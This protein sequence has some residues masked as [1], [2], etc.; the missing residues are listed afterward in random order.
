MRISKIISAVFVD[1]VSPT[2]V[3]SPNTYAPLIIWVL[4]TTFYFVSLVP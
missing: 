1:V 4:V 2:F 3:M